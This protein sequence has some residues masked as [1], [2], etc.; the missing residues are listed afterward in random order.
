MSRKI[1]FQAELIIFNVGT[2]YYESSYLKTFL[3]PCA[4]VKLTRSDVLALFIDELRD[5]LIDEGGGAEIAL[6]CG[7]IDEIRIKLGEDSRIEA[8]N[9]TNPI[10]IVISLNGDV[11]EEHCNILKNAI[12]S[13]K[14]V[15]FR[16]P[17]HLHRASQLF[18]HI[19]GSA[20]YLQRPDKGAAKEQ[21]HEYS[22]YLTKQR[23]ITEG[24]FMTDVSIQAT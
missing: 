2:E 23:F 14:R 7:F 9:L 15:L 22:E 1:H 12:S 17:K 3:N 18:K 21:K 20:I 16:A 24:S 8:D 5:R 13:N 6:L 19:I 10:S 11:K 4:F